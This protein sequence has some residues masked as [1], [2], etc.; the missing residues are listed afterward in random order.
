MSITPANINAR[1]VE[2]YLGHRLNHSELV[3]LVGKRHGDDSASVEDTFQHYADRNTDWRKDTS[4]KE[5]QSAL[6]ELGLQQQFEALGEDKVWS[7][8][9]RALYRRLSRLDFDPPSQEPAAPPSS[10]DLKLKA[11]VELS[12]TDWNRNGDL[13]LDSGELD[14]LLSGGF[15]GEKA[16]EANDPAKAA[17]LSTMLRYG[18]LLGAGDPSD[19]SGIT[20][21]DLSAWENNPELIASGAVARVNEIYHLYLKQAQELA[22]SQPIGGETIRGA[23]IYQGTSGSC[24][25]LSTLAGCSDSQLK[26]MIAD[27]GDGTLTVTF[28]DGAKETVDEP[29]LA[30]RLYHSQ[31]ANGERWPAVIEIATAQR[32]IAEGKSGKNGLR[33][34]I[35]G[36]DPE[37]AIKAFSGRDSKRESIDEL[38]IKNTRKLMQ[39]ALAEGGPVIAGS[40]PSANGDFINVEE[41]HNGII[42]GHCYAIKGYDAVSDSVKLQNPWHTKEWEFTS[43]PDGDGLFEMPL[44]DFYASFR[45]LSYAK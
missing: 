32:L 19:G 25:A 29:T 33:E 43:N 20:I 23:N 41:L 8:E 18:S 21:A 39:D 40:R 9:D 24:V 26:E 11:T 31:G 2:A 38:N 6:K 7:A 14:Y 36:I 34:A 17:A 44:K 37:F 28:A 22:L 5:V 1:I 12:F 15:Y 42:N 45:W 16:Q 27:N 4:E 35:N 30:E 10:L 13:A 3:D